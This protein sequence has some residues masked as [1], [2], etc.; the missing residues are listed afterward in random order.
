MGGT[1]TIE[2]NNKVISPE[3]VSKML[4]DYII[5]GQVMTMV[6]GTIDR[7]NNWDGPKYFSENVYG[8]E[9]ME[10]SQL[11]NEFTAWDGQRAFDLM[12]LPLPQEGDEED[13]DQK[14][15]REI[16]ETCLQRSFGF[17]LAHGMIIKVFKVTLGSLWRDNPGSDDI[18][19][20]YAHWLRYAIA[21]WNQD[22]LPP[23]MRF[24]R[25]PAYKIGS[26]LRVD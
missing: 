23:T 9:Y 26:L 4:T 20:T 3:E 18:P 10:G 16:V 6:L 14:L 5:Q 13:A 15:A 21:H 1:F 11:I 2:D 8:I 19:G 22:N 12:S 7:E 17:K 25:F 24:K